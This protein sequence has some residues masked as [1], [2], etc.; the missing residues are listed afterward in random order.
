MFDVQ[1]GEVLLDDVALTDVGDG[2]N[3][4]A[5]RGPVVKALRALRPGILRYQDGDHLGSS[6]DNMLAPVFA[7]QRAGFSE[8]A[9][10]QGVVPTGLGEFLQLCKAVGAEPWV[11]LPGGFSP[12]EMRDLVEYLSGPSTSVY[13]AKRMLVGQAEPWTNVFAKI[14]LELGNEEW[15][16]TTFAGEAMPDPVAYGQRVK[17]V[18]GAARAAAYYKP[19][20]F[21]LVMGSFALIPGWTQTELAAGGGYDSTAVAP[22]LFDALNDASSDAAVFG[23]MFAEPEMVDAR[24]GGYMAQQAQVVCSGSSAEL[25]VYEV[26]LGT[27]SGSASQAAFNRAVPSMGAGLTLIDHML[28]MMRDL[29]VKNQAVWALTGYQ[30]S[31][32]NSATQQAEMTPLFGT[33]VDM[34]GATNLRRPQYLTEQM[35]D[36][37]ILPTMVRAEIKGHDPVWQQ[38]LSANNNIALQNAHEL[39]TFAFAD[40]HERSLIVL[41]LSRDRALPVMFGGK[42]APAGEVEVSRLSAEKITDNNETEAK[43]VPVKSRVAGFDPRAG[44]VLPPFS[45][46]VLRWVVK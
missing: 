42:D 12:E 43:V 41:N 38:A 33:V 16:G 1:Q 36:E 46:T 3:E 26:N 24:P 25:S 14:H 37:A 8:Q 21:D 7:R 15:N 4:T 18:F 45:M 10:V 19:D 2:A 34:G 5:Y 30:N 20:A 40:G 11:T 31:F 17:Q 6:L 13:G 22:Y 23:P 9:S 32:T 27:A 39:Q 28:L 29:G 44:F 35:A